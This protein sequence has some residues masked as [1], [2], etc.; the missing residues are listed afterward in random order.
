MIN[1]GLAYVDAGRIEDAITLYEDALKRC[2]AKLGPDHPD[3]L[4]SRESLALA[5]ERARRFGD[6]RALGQE[7]LKRR[8]AKAG[9]DDP[10]T[11]ATLDSLAKIDLAVNPAEAEPFLR[12]AL[13]IRVKKMPDDWSTFDNQS[14]LGS[15][16]L[17]QKKYAEAEPLLLRGYD[18]LLARAAKIPA[19]A[20]NRVSDAL[21]RIVKLYEGWG[22]KDKADEWRKRRPS[23]PGVGAI[24]K[25][26]VSSPTTASFEVPACY[27]GSAQWVCLAPAPSVP[28]LISCTAPEM[29]GQK[30][31]ER[32]GLRA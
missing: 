15:S 16:L 28:W 2:E 12:Q 25:S 19:S 14:L 24:P 17:V 9:P 1:L 8:L 11:L 22:K 20:P 27:K 26:G 30:R 7:T 23:R 18:G 4:F 13:S 3:T 5:Y 21:D 32:H 10:E 6:A 29:S 31:H